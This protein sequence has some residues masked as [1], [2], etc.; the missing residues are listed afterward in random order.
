M[1][2]HL[3]GDGTHE[4]ELI[5]LLLGAHLLEG[6]LRCAAE[7]DDGRIGAFGKRDA[8]DGVRDARTAGGQ[9]HAE[10]PGHARIG[11]RHEGGR[12]LV[13]H[14]D[15]LDIV[16]PCDRIDDLEMRRADQS[17]DMT[18]AFG[19]QAFDN[20]LTGVHVHEMGSLSPSPVIL[21]VAQP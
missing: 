11:V 14:G 10:A 3:L 1:R 2:Q 19:A 6:C 16:R 12:L 7:R 8:G 18:H 4:V 21:A 20:R 17:E 15:E 13:P 9:D 5:D